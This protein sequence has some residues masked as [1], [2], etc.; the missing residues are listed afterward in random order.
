MGIMGPTA[1][2][3]HRRLTEP[4]QRVGEW[5][6]PYH[7]GY[8]AS[9]RLVLRHG[10]PV[11]AEPAVRVRH[12]DRGSGTAGQAFPS[13]PRISSGRSVIE[14]PGRPVAVCEAVARHRTANPRIFGSILSGQDHDGGD[15][16]LRFD[17]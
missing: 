3:G 14:C 11:L 12:P 10:A 13:N 4:N 6:A 17:T 9:T 5:Q 16:D 2:G 15:L 8:R 7:G 1:L